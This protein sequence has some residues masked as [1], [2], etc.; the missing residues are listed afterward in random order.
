MASAFASTCNRLTPSAAHTSK[1]TLIVCRPP[2]SDQDQNGHPNMFCTQ[3]SIAIWPTLPPTCASYITANVG[4]VPGLDDPGQ[5][6]TSDA[7]VPTTGRLAFTVRTASVSTMSKALPKGALDEVTHQAQLTNII[8]NEGVTEKLRS[9]QSIKRQDHF[10]PV[11]PLLRH[12]LNSMDAL[13]PQLL[14]T[15]INSKGISNDFFA[16]LAELHSKEDS[17][18]QVMAQ[19][20]GYIDSK[21]QDGFQSLKQSLDGDQNRFSTVTNSCIGATE[22]AFKHATLELSKIIQKFQDVAEAKVSGLEAQV[23]DLLWAHGT[24]EVRAQDLEAKIG[25]LSYQL[26]ELNSASRD[27]KAPISY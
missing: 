13:A 4:R 12:K 20:M 6:Q 15:H 2:P 17:V 11:M 23:M 24:L 27:P 14:D 19:V 25:E 18:L 8:M 10:D 22:E 21:L 16:S 26:E 3:A 1:Q 5:D 9:Q 7:V